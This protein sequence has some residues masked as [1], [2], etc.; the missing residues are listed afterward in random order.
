MNRENLRSINLNSLPILREI[1]RHG[2]IAKA[3]QQLN[4]TAPALSNTLRQLRG[5]FDD[6][7][8]VRDGRLM[9]LT[10]KGER[11]VPPLERALNSVS[12]VL[13]EDE[14]DI[15]QCSETLRI[16][17]AD[18]VVSTMGVRYAIIVER[19]APRINTHFSNASKSSVSDLMTG[20]IDIVI[21]PKFMLNGG[22]ADVSALQNVSM[23]PLFA[24][25]LVCIGHADDAELREGLSID[26]YLKRPHVSF[27]LDSDRHVSVE[28]AFLAANGWK[29]NDTMHVSSYSIL[30]NIVAT[31]GFISVVPESLARTACAIYPLQIAA[32][33]IPLPALDWTMV[34]HKRDDEKL[35]LEWL[36]RALQ[37]SVE[38]LDVDEKI[39]SGGILEA[40]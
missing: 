29:Q 28:Q 18:C 23:A 2:N 9:R 32:P 27:L 34:W 21:S 12:L 37:R 5:Y 15:S 22:I 31:T 36:R 20:R 25:R 13:R 3:A 19:E 4:L 10:P 30:P 16:V 1:L 38:G 24:D 17:T 14:F 40:A 7:L 8:I 6:E 26:R 11:I 33:P 39:E 35:S